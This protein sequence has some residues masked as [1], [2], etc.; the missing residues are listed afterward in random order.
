MKR[1]KYFIITVDT[2][3]DNLWGAHHGEPITTRN[4]AYIP[5]F[6]MLCNEYGFKPVYL[7]N[8]EMAIDENYVQ[9][10]KGITDKG[11]CEVG[12]HIHAWNNPPYYELPEYKCDQTF[13]L[14]YP[15]EIMRQK[16]KV[17]YD[18][19][20][21]NIGV[22]PFSHR[23]GRWA[24]DKRY[25]KLLEEFGIKVDCSYTP[26]VDWSDTMGAA[27]G[28]SNYSRKTAKAQWV[29]NIL[30]VPTS[31][32]DTGEKLRISTKGIIK[33]LLRFKSLPHK[34]IWL[35]PALSD[36][37][38][39]MK[40]INQIACDDSIDF[41]EFMIHSSELMPG[42]SPYFQ[43]K[44]SIESLYATM[45]ELFQYTKQKGFVGCTLKE[46]YEQKNQG[47]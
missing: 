4:T 11:Q 35:R 31:I 15:Y 28:G 19:I 18:L 1:K 38:S 22:V 37:L 27:R 33:R 25:F 21:K 23:A 32:Y 2:E 45:K 12:I 17:T 8:Y 44:E 10:I 34:V 6:Q 39:M 24:M 5:R 42:G 16:L 9:F 41:A 20:K 3:G 13:L 47:N 30:E 43:T 40:I 46:Y 14:E 36:L 26:H 7:T 29:G